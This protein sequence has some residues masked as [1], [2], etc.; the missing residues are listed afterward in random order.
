MTKRKIVDA[1]KDESGKIEAV[2]VEG[3]VNFTSV[4]RAYDMTKDGKLDLVAVKTETGVHVRTRPDK[5]EENN[6][7]QMADD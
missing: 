6:L 7:S 3:N 2:L 1:R 4:E 5:S